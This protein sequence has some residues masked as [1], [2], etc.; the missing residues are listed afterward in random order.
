MYYTGE[1]TLG[2][3]TLPLLGFEPKVLWGVLTDWLFC[4]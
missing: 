3:E 4:D 2:S 1:V